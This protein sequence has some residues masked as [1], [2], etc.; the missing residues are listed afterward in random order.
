MRVGVV[1][2]IHGNLPALEVVTDRIR[3]LDLVICLG[4]VVNYGPWSDECLELLH[5]LPRMI[6][7]EGNHEALFLGKEPLEHE[8]PLVQRFYHAT[9]GR[10]TR[11]D[12]IEDLPLETTLAGYLFTHTLNGQRIF[13]DSEFSPASDCFIGHTHH[14]FHISRDGRQVINPGSVGQNRA[15]VDLAC[16][17][18][19]DTETGQI[20]LEQVTYPVD[21]LLD[22][23]RRLEYPPECLAYYLGKLGGG[24]ARP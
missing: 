17:A 18:L 15:R 1:S 8:V 9:I 16:Y 10:F 14:P 24:K 6:L 19:F 4:D 21:V 11:R 5:T 13:K 12:L 20:S 2:D 3:D 23:M 7:L 22:E